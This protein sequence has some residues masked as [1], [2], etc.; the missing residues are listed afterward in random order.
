MGIKID[1]ES[2]THKYHY[3]LNSYVQQGRDHFSISYTLGKGKG[4]GNLEGLASITES[5]Q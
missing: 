2:K 1:I 5:R 4:C 3:E